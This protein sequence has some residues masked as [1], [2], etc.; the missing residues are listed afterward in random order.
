[1]AAGHLGAELVG[2][3]RRADA[4]HLVGGH[5]DANARGAD[6]HPEIRLASGHRP[7]SLSGDGGVVHRIRVVGAEVL[8]GDL[9]LLQIAPD[10]LFQ[11]EAAVVTAIAIFI[12]IQTPFRPSAVGLFS[13][14]F[15]QLPLR[16]GQA[17]VH[18]C[19]LPG[20]DGF[21]L[22]AACSPSSATEEARWYR[23]P[24]GARRAPHMENAWCTGTPRPPAGG[25]PG[26]GATARPPAP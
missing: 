13:L 15:F 19:Q 4:L 24:S 6:Q 12:S 16:L 8:I 3:Q 14:A 21:A 17:Q 22:L 10:S 9:T 23:T 11:L 18:R 20:G 5:G 25:P 26:H 2:A 1:M 7:G